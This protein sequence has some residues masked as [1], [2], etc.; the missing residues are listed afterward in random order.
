MTM[1]YEAFLGEALSGLKRPHNYRRFI[2]LGRQ[3][4]RFPPALLEDAH[5]LG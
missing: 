1:N 3:T 4:E 5:G 2:N